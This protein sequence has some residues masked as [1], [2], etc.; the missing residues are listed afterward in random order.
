MAKVTLNED[1]VPCSRPIRASLSIDFTENLY[2][3]NRFVRTATQCFWL[4]Q[5]SCV[6]SGYVCD[7]GD[8]FVV[9]VWFKDK[10]Y[11][12]V[13]FQGLGYAGMLYV[14]VQTSLSDALGQDLLGDLHENPE[15]EGLEMR[16]SGRLLEPLGAC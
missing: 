7:G 14:D 11:R 8:S 12:S 16:V 10:R 3:A 5:G 9:E 2:L 6:F 15:R 1:L 4:K 13:K